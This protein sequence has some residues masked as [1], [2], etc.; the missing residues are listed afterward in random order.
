MLINYNKYFRVSQRCLGSIVPDLKI[1]DFGIVNEPVLGY[2]K[3]SKEREELERAL[4]ETASKEEDIPIV[5]GQ[6]KIRTNEVRYQ[7]SVFYF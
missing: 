2:L 5:I 6:E 1:N 7:V 3:G 4:K